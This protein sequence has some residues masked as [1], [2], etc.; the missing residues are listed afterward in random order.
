MELHKLFYLVLISI[1]FQTKLHAQN[2]TDCSDAVIVCGNSNINLDV[3]GIGK[4]ELGFGTNCSSQ[5]NNSVWLKVAPITDGTLG[6][7]LKPGSSSINEDYD[8]FVFGPNANCN[9]IGQAIRCSTTNPASAGLTSNHTGM[10]GTATDTSEGPGPNGNSFVSWLNVLAGETYFIVID[11]PIGN[12]DFSLEWTGTA[13]F[14]DPPVDSSVNNSFS[15]NIETCD[16]DLP[17]NDGFSSFDLETN[18]PI[19]LGTQTDATISY[20]DSESDAIINTNPLTSPYTNTKNPQTIYARITNKSTGCFEVSEFNLSVNSGPSFTVPSDYVLCDNLDDGDDKNGRTTFNLATK[21]SDILKGNDPNNVNITYYKSTNDAETKTNPHPNLY[22]NNTP[23]SEEIFFRIE[24]KTNPLCR[25]I[26]SFR[27]ISNPN[28]EAYNHTLLQCDEDGVS[29]GFTTFNL[30]ESHADL[31]GNLKDRTT[32]FFTDISRTSEVNGDSFLN[33]TN[34][35]I[36]YVEV[37]NTLTQCYSLS[38]LTLAVST[39]DSNNATLALCDYD[40]VEDGFHEFLLSEADTQITNGLPTG[41]QISYY[42]TY[43]DALLE[44]NILGNTFINTIAHSQTIYARVENANNCYG[45]SDVNLIVYKLPEL[46][47]DEISY[48]CL[49]AFP[50][51][52]ALTAG[53]KNDSTSNY[54]YSWSTAE[55]SYQININTIGNYTVTATNANGCSKSR[56]ITIEASNVAIIN[57]IEVQ[58][59]SANNNITVFASGEGIYEYRL[60]N[61][62]N[63]IIA[64][65]QSSPVFNNIPPGVYTVSVKDIKNDCGIVNQKVFVIGFPKFFTPNHDGHHDTWQV[66][67]VSSLNQ[68]NSKIFIYDRYGKLLKQLSPSENGWNGLYGGKKLPA[69]DYWFTIN[70]EDGR[71]FKDHFTLKY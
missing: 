65:Y 38:E 14:S 60:I 13:T 27:L 29:D 59:A 31:T 49:N 7:T 39:T 6:F 15:K 42:E 45:I 32:R 11:R 36:I 12:S 43:N 28:P 71:I 40:G 33:T 44:T 2:P 51:E 50:E 20:H 5:E 26:S 37:E 1:I 54:T 23:F 16:V 57:N 48:Y 52:K 70:L 22:Y 34:P 67:G 3:N 66:Y 69:D 9:N 17:Y 30:N 19:I 24:D 10:N 55:T 4:Q 8:F 56:T 18:T 62:N 61:S 63:V 46:E 53:I 25:S 47:S 21:N 68:S 35:Q 64:P 41:L 58:D